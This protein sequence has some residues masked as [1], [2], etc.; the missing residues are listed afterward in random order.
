MKTFQ[1]IKQISANIQQEIQAQF[2][3]VP[4]N[5]KLNVPYICQYTQ[6][7]EVENYKKRKLSVINDP[8]WK[9]NGAN[10]PQEYE[11]WT[12]ALCGM[13]TTAMAVKYY[14]GKKVKLITLAKDAMSHGV[15]HYESP[16]IVSDM[17]YRKFTKWI[18]KYGLLAEVC[19]ILSLKKIHHALANNRLPI[20]SV[21]PNICGYKTSSP[22]RKGGHLVL[23]VGYDLTHHVLFL[24]NPS[25]F[26]SLKTQKNYKI[27]EKEFHTFYA[28]R[29]IL[30]SS[31]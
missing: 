17:Q 2:A 24:H 14:Q 8:N 4:N 20:V 31:K 21:N 22:R 26:Y 13:A 27:S 5:I 30:V 16:G 1:Q 29:G 10:T 23:V 6:P 7:E 18:E 12:H 3:R 19:L 15:Y 25:G 11:K 9:K 28:K